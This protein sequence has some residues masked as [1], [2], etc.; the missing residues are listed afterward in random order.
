M[1]PAQGRPDGGFVMFSRAWE[2]RRPRLRRA[3]ARSEFSEEESEAEEESNRAPKNARAPRTKSA[4][5]TQQK[6][7]LPSASVKKPQKL[8][9]KRSRK[10]CDFMTTVGTS[11]PPSQYQNF[12][13][14]SSR[15]DT[16]SPSTSLPSPTMKQTTDATKH[17]IENFLCSY[18]YLSCFSFRFQSPKS[19]T[20]LFM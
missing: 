15:S 19:K 8:F 20:N 7:G 14:S 18:R 3:Y 16:R 11:P 2:R 12:A 6:N 10:Q 1:P 5:A 13:Q 9:P 4:A 17:E